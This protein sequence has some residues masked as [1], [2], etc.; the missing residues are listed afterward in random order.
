MKAKLLIFLIV[1]VILGCE[2]KE[3]G[4]A[5]VGTWEYAEENDTLATQPILLILSQKMILTLSKDS[6]QMMMQIKLPPQINNFSDYIGF[7]GSMT[8][9]GEDVEIIFKEVGMREINYQTFTFIDDEVTWYNETDDP[10]MFGSLFYEY[11]PDD[12]TISGKLIV[13]GNK[14]T[15]K[16]DEDLNGQIDEEEITVFTRI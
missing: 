4:P 3:E 1:A 5:Y 9:D 16:M 2:K 10:N 15:M 7:K 12:T 6:W 11:G 14:L 13:E 8:V